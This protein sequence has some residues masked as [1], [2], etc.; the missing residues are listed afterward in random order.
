[1]PARSSTSPRRST[2]STTGRTS[3]TSTRRPSPTSWPAT[4]GCGARRCSSSPAPTSTPPRSSMPPPSA[5]S[6]P[7]SG[8]TTTPRPSRAPSR[9]WASPTTTS[10]APPSSGTRTAS[11]AWSGNSFESGDVYLGEYEGW[12]D[13]GQE[14]YVPEN[15]A[16]ESDYKSPINGK[17]LVRKREKNYFFRLS[18]YGDAL[19][20]HIAD[21]P[22]AVEP[23]A[24]RN[25][26]VG[27]IRDGLND[28]PISRAGGG[29]LGHPLSRRRDPQH[30]RVDRRAHQLPLGGGHRRRAAISGPP[31]STSSPRT[32]SG[33]TP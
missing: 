19:L 26:V 1:M 9:A 8:P 2:T 10:S 6:A 31:T 11:I 14:E 24:R 17:P 5:G 29:G 32:S 15:K 23:A 21:H 25:E 3:V 33:S 12:Y 22:E 28:V 20:E 7:R 13:A 4:T 27:R 16:T 18:S 30:L